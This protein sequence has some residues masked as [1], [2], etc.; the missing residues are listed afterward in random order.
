MK[1]KGQTAGVI[2]N[3]DNS[4]NLTFN[5]ILFPENTRLFAQRK[6]DL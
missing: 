5:L 1:R 4:S 2:V 3:V 6:T